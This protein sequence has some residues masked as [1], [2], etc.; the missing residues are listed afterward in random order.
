MRLTAYIPVDRANRQ[1]AAASVES[2][3]RQL[4]SGISLLI[5]AEG[6]RSAD[7]RLRPFK[8]GTCVTA[9]QAGVPV[10]PVSIAGTKR[11]MPKGTWTLHP[12][13]VTIHFG[14]AVDPSQYT[15][16]R[17]GEL[18]SRIESLVAAGLPP[19]QQP[20]SR[21]RGNPTE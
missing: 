11:L 21:E 5:F 10:V 4:R 15:P 14:S 18:L 13:E 6:T 9:I 1:S 17:R 12:G 16:D 19:E 7:G 20:V 8:R 2:A 3:V